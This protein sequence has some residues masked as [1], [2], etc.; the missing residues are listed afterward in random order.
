MNSRCSE[1]VDFSDQFPCEIWVSVI[2]VY[3]FMLLIA[4]TWSQGCLTTISIRG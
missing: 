2:I 3:L 1:R 4:R